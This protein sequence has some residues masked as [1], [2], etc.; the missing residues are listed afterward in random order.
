MNKELLEKGPVMQDNIKEKKSYQR[1]QELGGV[2]N[3]KDYRNAK[4]ALER[5]N[6]ATT[7]STTQ[8]QQA[9]NI[10]EHAEIE[11]INT[12]D[13]LD[14]RLILYGILH[15][16]KPWEVKDSDYRIFREA[17]RVLDDTDALDKLKTTYHTNRPHGTYCPLCDQTGFSESCP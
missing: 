11:F 14:K 3:E 13:S 8:I 4:D 9:E 17:L 16:I 5:A 7:L 12:E 10:A 1:Y 15:D 6:G 2:I